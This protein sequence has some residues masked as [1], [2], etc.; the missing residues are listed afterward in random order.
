[1]ESINTRAAWRPCLRPV[2][3]VLVV[4]QLLLALHP[5]SALAQGKVQNSIGPVA[6]AQLE[7]AAQWSQRQQAARVSK[8]QSPADAISDKLA[9]AQEIAAQLKSGR[10]LNRA[11]KHQQLKALLRD[12][13]VGAADVRFE[14]AATRVVLQKKSLPAE[15]LVRHDEAV[16]QFE[17]RSAQFGQ[18]EA[19]QGSDDD[20]ASEVNQFFQRYPARKRHTPIDSGTLPWGSP[21]AIPRLPAENK[22]A[23]F[24]SLTRDQKV[25]LAQAG[26]LTTIGGVQFSIPPEPGQAPSE[27]DLA[28]T[29]DTQVTPAIRAKAQE[30]GYSPVN[31]YNWVANNIQWLPTWGSIQGADGTLK[32]LR[33]N[34]LDTSSLTI[35]LL[36]ASGIPARYQFGTMDVPV[37]A[38]MNWIGG[39][40]RP[41]AVLN[42]LY[43]GGVA[44]RGIAGAGRIATIRMEH[45]WVNAYV[46]WTPSR[47]ARQGGALVNPRALAPHGQPQHPNP[48]GQLNAWVPLDT[49]FKQ[50][51]FT[52]GMDLKTAVPVDANV[53]I[54]AAQQ[55]ATV[56]AN[57]AQNLNQAN[58]QAQL[59]G[60][61][62]RLQSYI[63][64]TPTGG[65]STVGDVLGT[66]TIRA[67]NFQMLPGTTV[68]PVVAQGPEVKEIPDLLRWKWRFRLF[69][70]DSALANDSPTLAVQL[71]A[72]QVRGRKFTLSFIPASDADRQTIESY[73]PKLHADGSPIQLSDLPSSL[74]GYLIRLKAEVRLDGQLVASQY[75]SGANPTAQGW[76]MG[77]ELA[78]RAGLFNP[79][80]GRWEDAELNRP[81]VGE[82]VA[83]AFDL[84]GIAQTDLQ[85]LKDRLMA[86][87]AALQ[88]L[89]SNPGNAAGIAA[90]SKEEL[91]GDLL[92]ANA[93]SYFTAVQTAQALSARASGQIANRLP[94]FGN[95]Q[96]VVQT[97]YSWGIPRVVTFPGMQL[98]MDRISVQAS[99]KN[100]LDAANEEQQRTGSLRQLGAI[101]SAFEHTVPEQLFGRDPTGTL[102]A[103]G[104]SAVKILAVAAS[105]GQKIF[106]F[107]TRNQADHASM[108]GQ[109]T[110]EEGVKGEIANA[111]ANG[112]EV[113][114]HE[115]PIAENGFV[116][117]G[118]TLIDPSTGAGAWKV[119]GGANGGWV[120][121]AGEI[122]IA[123]AAGALLFLSV[124]GV[125]AQIVLQVLAF[126]FW[127][128]A[129]AGAIAVVAG[130]AAV[131]YFDA[132]PV[133][134]SALRF[135]IGGALVFALLAFGPAAVV[136]PVAL[137]LFLGF[138]L[139]FIAME[140]AIL[141][142]LR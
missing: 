33:G 76:Q 64:S 39:V 15:I 105:Q 59:T 112:F 92:Y 57:Y 141:I 104:Y 77:T 12:I 21:K 53:V 95:F 136:A 10:T 116:G 11:E 128:A 49:S 45:V 102:Q 44:A 37:A 4:A 17:Q 89:Q 30:L 94:S 82:S 65:S 71:P 43:Q 6:Q 109:I 114:I 28:E 106:T 72:T 19:R 52:A 88:T 107:T 110:V 119:S 115:A 74:P 138:F 9:Q 137:K 23:W 96:T 46:N 42:L 78:S 87:Q 62:S 131:T 70:D 35:A 50:Y 48:N 69:A 3:R 34:A 134:A 16:A 135:F 8:Q 18:I 36:R 7:R 142:A 68:F 27:A 58:L 26:A 132:D 80:S 108:L 103:N 61:Q 63:N 133:V 41:E 98:D 91:V 130:Y 24:E 5:L 40:E 56:T 83:T 124:A 29:T 93:L 125:I 20:K 99:P 66:Q 2:G 55:G 97:L 123:I 118:Y 120:G 51:T 25:H 127:A 1:M 47:G 73:L 86:T 101:M 60:Y 38:M 79:A 129:I 126:P 54:Q 13:N 81:T 85:V 122:G 111:L 14:F 113:T 139:R 75:V 32:T 84:Q 121:T 31:I 67:R 22:T 117:S 100:W 140:Y 90:L